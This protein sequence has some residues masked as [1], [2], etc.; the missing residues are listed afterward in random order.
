MV[1]YLAILFNCAQQTNNFNQ[2]RKR[3]LGRRKCLNKEHVFYIYKSNMVKTCFPCSK[4]WNKTSCMRKSTACS[5]L[6]GYALGSL[7]N[8]SFEALVSF[9]T[10]FWSNIAPASCYSIVSSVGRVRCQRH[11][12]GRCKMWNCRFIKHLRA[13]Y[14]PKP[15]SRVFLLHTK[16]IQGRPHIRGQKW[17]PFQ[18]PKTNRKQAPDIH[19]SWSWESFSCCCDA[20]AKCPMY[21]KLIR[22]FQRRFGA[23]RGS[24]RPARGHG[25]KT[26]WHKDKARL[27]GT[28]SC[29]WEGVT[30]KVVVSQG[31]RG[32]TQCESRHATGPF[33]ADTKP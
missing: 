7:Q 14:D 24:A 8:C 28:W 5:L 18:M 19:L 22:T 23:L 27:T 2:R 11:L 1:F 13:A 12:I 17:Y 10:S 33:S 29:T 20:D 9:E 15:G 30:R 21:W 6:R 32:I 4:H 26:Y 16:P 25:R 31:K 3:N